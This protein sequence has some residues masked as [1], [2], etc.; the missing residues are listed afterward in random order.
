LIGRR[1]FIWTYSIL[2]VCVVTLSASLAQIQ[3]LKHLSR[4]AEL[5][6]SAYLLRLDSYQ[7]LF[8]LTRFLDHSA[9]VVAIELGERG[10]PPDKLT[11][12]VQ[13]RV[14][15]W[16]DLIVNWLR[17]Q[18]F[19]AKLVVS[20][21]R[22]EEYEEQPIDEVLSSVVG[23]VAGVRGGMYISAR[24]RLE[25]TDLYTGMRCERKFNIAI[26]NGV[27]YYLL[28]QLSEDYL[29]D[30]VTLLS[31]LDDRGYF[32]IEDLQNAVNDKVQE[33]TNAFIKDLK[34]WGVEGE[35]RYHI[36]VLQVGDSEVFVGV[37]VERLS[38][39]DIAG[40]K[41]VL[42]GFEKEL[43]LCRREIYVTHIFTLM[44]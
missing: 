28:W 15:S 22:I 38:L 10:E 12:E 11:P 23:R 8:N 21:L 26:P 43:I 35:I 14:A 20:K 7:V 30:I 18:G 44:S 33:H 6:S 19:E 34:E 16:K 42:N 2:I 37:Y 17:D 13:C 32:S 5:R 24:L 1:A 41:V 25:I 3:V 36:D 40:E 29:S 31:A 9:S 39:I 4:S 27:R